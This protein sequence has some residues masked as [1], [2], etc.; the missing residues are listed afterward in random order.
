MKPSPSGVRNQYREEV[1]NEH[2][3]TRNRL[4]ITELDLSPAAAQGG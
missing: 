4:E 2:Y 3:A 1:T